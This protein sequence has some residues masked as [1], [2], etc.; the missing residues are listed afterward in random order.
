MGI[1]RTGT[2]RG[3]VIEWGVSVTSQKKLPQFVIRARL[4]EYYDQQESEWFDYTD[5]EAEVSAYL[6]LYGANKSKGGEIGPTL[7]LD[8]V[9]KVFGWDGASMA[10]LANGDYSEL[11]IQLRIGDNTYE[12][13]K[14]PYQVDWIDEYDADPVRQLQKLSTTELKDLDKQFA[15]L[16]TKK[17]IKAVSAKKP[18]VPLYAPVVEVPAVEAPE[19]PVTAAEKKK[20]MKEKSNRIKADA[21][22]TAKA[23][24]E[25][26]AEM[27]EPPEAPETVPAEV[28]EAPAPAE[29]TSCTKNEAWCGILEMRDPTINDD[30]IK[31]LWNF[32]IA[33]IA[34]PKA[35]T[36]EGMKE[37]TNEQWHQIMEAV[38]KD[39][40]KF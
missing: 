21:E 24:A 25:A 19:K 2:F 5:Q 7:S 18:S 13:A 1:D 23:K 3:L 15:N 4:T 38:L 29:S 35:V 22:A 6:C 36:K 34:G 31:E 30:T 14:T 16:L 12:E 10:A 40:A 33:E 27:P 17:S 32:A 11:Q 20:I 37:V 8:Q 26:K 39:C 9:K 28:P